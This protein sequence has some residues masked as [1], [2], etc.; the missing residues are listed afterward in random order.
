MSQDN[1][2]SYSFL[3]ISNAHGALFVNRIERALFLLKNHYPLL[4]EFC[5]DSLSKF[6]NEASESNTRG[7]Y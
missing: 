5:Y 3:M 7:L 1:T 2:E 6:K 4:D